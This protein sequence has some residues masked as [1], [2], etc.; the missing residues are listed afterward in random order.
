MIKTKSKCSTIFIN[1]IRSGM[2]RYKPEVTSGGW[3]LEF[4]SSVRLAIRRVG[5]ADGILGDKDSPNGFRTKIKVV[6]NKVGP[7]LRT[8]ETSLYIGPDKYGVDINEE[9]IDVAIGVD[10]I[11]RARKDKETGELVEDQ[12]GSWYI[13]DEENKFYGLNKLKTFIE[14]NPESINTLK[15][16]VMA[17]LEK[18]HGPEPDSFAARV[19]ETE[20][21][22]K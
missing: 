17:F 20:N 11:K 16:Q 21:E 19:N 2:S 15:E 7:P 1:Q 3:S 6:K 18:K 12:S 9:V 5:G 13:F 8:I 4:Y 14:E 10:L 22:N